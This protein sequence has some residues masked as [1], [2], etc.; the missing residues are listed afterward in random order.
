MPKR[1]NKRRNKPAAQLKLAKER[2]AMLLERSLSIHG[3]RPDLSRRYYQLAKKIGMRYN[4]H[5]PGE[6]KRKFCKN[7]FSFLEGWRLKNGIMRATCRECGAIARY[8]YKGKQK[9]AIVK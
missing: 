1:K 8:P 3:E 7:C 9:Q 5:M 2:M 6:L 4:V